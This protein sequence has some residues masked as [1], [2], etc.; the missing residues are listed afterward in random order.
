MTQRVYDE[1]MKRL[2]PTLE[3]NE[4]YIQIYDD[5]TKPAKNVS[6]YLN[7]GDTLRQMY[8]DPTL[9]D[10][11]SEI[12]DAINEVS[13]SLNEAVEDTKGPIR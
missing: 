12:W 6:H 1:M 9:E 13:N 8:A 7:Y 3:G 2:K 5:M 4:E 10:M 11:K